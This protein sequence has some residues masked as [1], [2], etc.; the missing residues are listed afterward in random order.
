MDRKIPNLFWRGKLPM[1]PKLR[2]ELI[3]VTKGKS[4][5]M[6]SHCSYVVHAPGSRIMPVQR[7]NAI[8]CLLLM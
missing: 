1:A 2:N 3:A 8:P 7:I 4:G 5:A 6:W